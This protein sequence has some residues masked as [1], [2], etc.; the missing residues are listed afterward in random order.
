RVLRDPYPLL[1]R[2]RW[3]FFKFPPQRTLDAGKM[4]GSRARYVDRSPGRSE[5][6]RGIAREFETVK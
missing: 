2:A 4:R 1:R 5:D 6:V 3:I